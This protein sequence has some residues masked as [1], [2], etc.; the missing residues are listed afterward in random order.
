MAKGTINKVFILGR[1]GQEPEEKSGLSLFSVATNSGYKDK[2]GEWID[3]TDWHSIVAYG[4]KADFCQTYV[5][6]GALVHIEGKI[7]YYKKEKDDGTK[8]IKTSISVND[9]TLISTGKK[10]IED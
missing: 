1:V 9:I 7:T 6:K 3:I 4:K 8:T 5:K 10:G 2:E